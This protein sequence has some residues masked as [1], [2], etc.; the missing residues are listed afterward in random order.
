METTLNRKSALPSAGKRSGEHQAVENDALDDYVRVALCEW[1]HRHGLKFDCP[2]KLE[3]IIEEEFPGNR[4]EIDALVSAFRIGV[5][6][7]LMWNPGGES[8]Q[9]LFNRLVDRL[10]NCT[11]LSLKAARWAIESWVLALNYAGSA[12][13]EKANDPGSGI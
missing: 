7:D 13:T 4:A 10:F 12:R 6:G 3:A 1:V 5:P 11:G 8:A 9:V 2:R